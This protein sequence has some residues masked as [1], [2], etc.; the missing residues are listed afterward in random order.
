MPS[1]TNSLI[2]STKIDNY[3]KK[4]SLP[5][6]H[7]S[8]FLFFCQT[9]SH[10]TFN[11]VSS[12]FTFCSREFRCSSIHPLL[13]MFINSVWWWQ[14]SSHDDKR[15]KNKTMQFLRCIHSPLNTTMWQKSFKQLMNIVAIEW[16][17]PHETDAWFWW[18]E[19]KIEVTTTELLILGTITRMQNYSM[20]HA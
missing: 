6:S 13:W 10:S 7:F 11:S 4:F 1:K 5:F 20:L 3:K 14:G 8:L 17:T 12:C 2:T 19:K 18:H 15:E 16:G 9:R